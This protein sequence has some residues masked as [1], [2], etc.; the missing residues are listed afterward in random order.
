MF[1]RCAKSRSSARRIAGCGIFTPQALA[2]GAARLH[3]MSEI[4]VE[5]AG[6]ITIAL[7]VCLGIFVYPWLLAH[8]YGAWI[9]AVMTLLLAGLFVAFQL[10]ASGSGSG[11]YSVALAARLGTG[12]CHRRRYRVATSAQYR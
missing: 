2:I 4:P 5:V 11:L 10:G 12:S 3:G 8:R 9:V 1:D 7:I 6:A